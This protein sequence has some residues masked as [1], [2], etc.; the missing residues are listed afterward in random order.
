MYSFDAQLIS[1]FD[2]NGHDTLLLEAI[3]GIEKNNLRKAPRVEIRLDTKIIERIKS[4]SRDAIIL[5]GVTNDL[6]SNG[7][8]LFTNERVTFKDSALYLAEFKIMEDVFSLPIRLVRM[9]EASSLV[10]YRFDYVFTFLNNPESIEIK[11]LAMALF[12]YSI[13]GKW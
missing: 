2:R 6:S 10:R 11:N 4:Q 7:L 9:R 3:T 8:S 12:E 5:S 1:G 13:R